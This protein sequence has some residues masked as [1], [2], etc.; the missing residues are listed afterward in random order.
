MGK[1]EQG[2]RK[3]AKKENIQ[4]ALLG[5]MLTTGLLLVAVTAPNM[6]RVLKHVPDY[7]FRYRIDVAA[8]R[9]VQKGKAEWVKRDGKSF[10]R[11]TEKGRQEIAYEQE[12]V[13]LTTRK[14]KRWDGKWRMVVFDVPERRRSVRFRL[15]GV[16]REVGF[17]RLQDSVWVY[18]Y[19][20]EEFVTLLKAELKIGKEVLYAIVDVIEYDKPI[21]TYFHLP[22]AN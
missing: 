8:K 10:L 9:L 7:R 22:L 17:M 15:R 18:P 4:R 19:D 13:S 20:C 14:Q 3:R 2:A 16:M 11:I 6:L 5:A 21:R 1:L 12:R